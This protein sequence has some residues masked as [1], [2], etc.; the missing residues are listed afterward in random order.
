VTSIYVLEY[1]GK[2]FERFFNLGDDIQ[3]LAISKLLPRVDGYVSRE[4]LDQVQEPCVVPMNGFFMNTDHWPPSDQVKPVFFSFHMTPASRKIICSPEGI[5]YL[6]KAQPIGCRDRGTM[7]ALSGYGLDVYYSRCVTLTLPRR[8]EEPVDGKIFI[9]GIGRN[10]RY[11]IPGDIRKVAITVDQ[12]KVR[13]PITNTKLKLELA[14]ELLEQYRTR[15]KLVITSKIHCAMPCIA[16]GI[17]V[18]FLYDRAK[19]DDYRIKIIEEFVPINYVKSSGVLAK[20]ANYMLSKRIDWSP[21]PLDI[22]PLKQ[23]IRD[24]FLSAFERTMQRL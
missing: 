21:D 14:E 15:A 11:S 1:T 24:S 4:S 16:M 22:Q 13:L 5:N 18:V 2:I 10:E 7:A 9:V 12:A 20:A 19:R 8:K 3:S 6:R 17:P 23:E